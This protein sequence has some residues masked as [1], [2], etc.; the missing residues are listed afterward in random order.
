MS[1][2][3]FFT[4]IF[5]ASLLS[6]VIAVGGYRLLTPQPR[7][8][9]VNDDEQQPLLTKYLEDTTFV[10]PEGLNFVFAAEKVTPTVVHIRSTYNG[11]GDDAQAGRNPLEEFFREYWGDGQRAPRDPHQRRGPARAFGSGVLISEDGYI[12]TNNHVV[13]DADEVQVTLEDNRVYDAKVIGTDPTT[14]LALLKIE[15]DDLPFVKFGNSDVVRVGEWVLAVGNPFDLTSTVTAGIVSA[16]ARNINILRDQSGLQIESFI[17]TDA[18]VNRG[19]SGGALVNLKGDLIG[20]NTAIITPTGVNAGYSFAVPS[21]IV[22]KVMRDLKEFGTVQRA[23]LGVQIRSVDADLADQFNLNT[24]NGVYILGVTEG[25][26]ARDAGIEDGDVIVSVNEVQIN[27]V[28]EL[29]EQ[30]A[31]YRPGDEVDVVVIRNNKRRNFEVKLKNNMGDTQMVRNES[32]ISIGGARF[33]E[34]SEEEAN[35]LE[36]QGGVRVI[37]LSTGKFKAAGVEEGFII[38]SVNKRPIRSVNDLMEALQN[39]SGGMLFEGVNPDG[40]ESYY[41]IGW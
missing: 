9:E 24:L 41:A 16:K 15:E 19:N 38:T 23:L 2:K 26:A 40:S 31:R 20:I 7:V 30:I 21:S 27:T 14:D 34:V 39:N 25:S 3:Q 6:G 18:A 17:Q 10:V 37:D 13:E 8:I 4:G 32:S 33:R 29:Q 22:S 1:R 35:E 11:S 12:A 5:L 28:S 36:I